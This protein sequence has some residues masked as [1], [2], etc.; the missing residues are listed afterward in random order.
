MQ[1]SDHAP[2]EPENEVDTKTLSCLVPAFPVSIG[3]LESEHDFNR[4]LAIGA[5]R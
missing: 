3:R 5:G 1:M 4:L 2:K